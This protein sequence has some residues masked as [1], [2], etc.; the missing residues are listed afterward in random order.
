MSLMLSTFSDMMASF[1][2]TGMVGIPLLRVVCCYRFWIE[3]CLS[4]L[5]LILMKEAENSLLFLENSC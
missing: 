1:Y 5:A 2:R 3:C 4:R